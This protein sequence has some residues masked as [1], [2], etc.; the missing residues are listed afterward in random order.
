MAEA[1]TGSAVPL[2]TGWYSKVPSRREMTDGSILAAEVDRHPDPICEAIRWH[3]CEGELVQIIGRARGINRTEVDPVDVLVMTDAPLPLPLAGTINAAD[4]TPAPAEMMLGVGGIAYENATH[5]SHAYPGLWANRKAAESAFAR[6]TSG[7]MPSN[8]YRRVPIREC[9]HLDRVAYQRAGARMS[10]AVALFDPALIPDPAAALAEKLG[11]LA[12]ATVPAP[13]APYG[14]APEVL[15]GYGNRLAPVG[16]FLASTTCAPV[17]ELWTIRRA[18]LPLSE[19]MG[20]A[21]M[22]PAVAWQERIIPGRM[23]ALRVAGP[24]SLPPLQ[25]GVQPHG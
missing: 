6:A 16:L 18:G 5:A 8:P 13:S 15:G 22:V 7:Q 3:I 23:H 25:P 12:W 2:L 10:R 24:A 1:L 21:G 9:R 14:A 4:L 20:L 19:V 11:P 17:S